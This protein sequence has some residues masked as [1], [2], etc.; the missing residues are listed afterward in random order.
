MKVKGKKSSLTFL[1]NEG[2]SLAVA[3]FMF[4]SAN[5]SVMARFLIASL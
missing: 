3:L 1:M 4:A 5:F 2:D